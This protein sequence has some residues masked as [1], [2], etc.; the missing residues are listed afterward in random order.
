MPRSAR[1][2]GGVADTSQGGQQPLHTSSKEGCL[3]LFAVCSL[4]LLLR[5]SRGEKERNDMG[6]AISAPRR[7]FPPLSSSSSCQRVRLNH[8]WKQSAVIQSSWKIMS[9]SS[10]RQRSLQWWF[11]RPEASAL[12]IT[13]PA[14]LSHRRRFAGSIG[15]SPFPHDPSIVYCKIRSC[16][17][18]SKHLQ[19]SSSLS[20]LYVSHQDLI[21]PMSDPI[22]STSL[23]KHKRWKS[24]SNP[25]KWVKQFIGWFS[26][27]ILFL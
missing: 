16:A 24:Q 17:L 6:E 7:L 2:E 22:P 18:M 21:R 23:T 12:A 19:R 15:A 9:F 4:L 25:N 20:P 3:F 8:P 1:A 11:A 10:C 26:E 14:W 27:K 5:H 13:R